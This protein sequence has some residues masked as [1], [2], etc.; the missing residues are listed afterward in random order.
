MTSSQSVRTV[1][2][3][4]KQKRKFKIKQSN[5]KETRSLTSILSENH[6]THQ[7]ECRTSKDNKFWNCFDYSLTDFCPHHNKTAFGYLPV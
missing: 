7:M 1:Y 3:Y 6:R 2:N 5:L 4:I